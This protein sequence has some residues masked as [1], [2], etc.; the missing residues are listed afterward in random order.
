LVAEVGKQ[1]FFKIRS[2][3]LKFANSWAHS[4][5]ANPQIFIINPKISTQYCTTLF[6]NS[7]RSSLFTS[8]LLCT[9]NYS[10]I[11]YIFM[12]KSMYCR[13]SEALSLQITKDWVTNRKSV[14]KVRKGDK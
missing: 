3:N 5:I 12:R 7:H 6:Q 8:F 14:Q 10:I 9:F 1:T 13:I 11:Y 2:A 4:A